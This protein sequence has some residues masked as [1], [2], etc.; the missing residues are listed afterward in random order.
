[1]KPTESYV[2]VNKDSCLAQGYALAPV[3]S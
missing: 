3:P 1:M 2:H